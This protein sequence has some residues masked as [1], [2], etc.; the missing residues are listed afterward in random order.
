VTVVRESAAS[1]P[2]R[3]FG[4]RRLA[5]AVGAAV[6]VAVVAVAT[7]AWIDDDDDAA[8]PGASVASACDGGLDGPAALVSVDREDGSRR[9]SRKVGDGAGVAELDGVIVTVD[10]DGMAVAVDAGTGAY[11]W[12]R[13][14][15]A[16]GET[17]LVPTERAAG[18][19]P[20]GSSAIVVA[21]DVLVVLI[22]TQVT[23]VDP[24]TGAT[25]WEREI[26]PTEGAALI[27]GS[28]VYVT[29]IRTVTT[30]PPDTEEGAPQPEPSAPVVAAIDPATGTLVEDA[31]PPPEGHRTGAGVL[32]E[33]SSTSP[34]R[35]ELAVGIRDATTGRDRWTKVVPGFTASLVGDTVL[36]LDQ[37]GGTG[38]ITRIAGGLSGVQTVL[39]AYAA[40][41]GS[42]RWRVDLPGTPQQVFDV[43]GATVLVADESELFAVD[44]ASGAIRWSEDHGS[45]G[46]SGV[47]S[48]PGS[49]RWFDTGPD[50]AI[51]GLIVAEK[52]YED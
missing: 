21:G 9:W 36:V 43:G 30:V 23:A 25:R 32:L 5:A 17:H 37:T 31:P 3:R 15:G 45:P 4:P 38:D 34:S 40:S 52:P 14:V 16:P 44:L 8:A 19:S 50:G 29:G 11:T 48:E 42:Q 10:T 22:G 13:E 49:Y 51:A 24:R 35:Q 18:A 46:V 6:L 27:G 47:Y 41:D 33:E 26:A 20:S 28:T 39:S 1:A 7:T 2:R 12:C